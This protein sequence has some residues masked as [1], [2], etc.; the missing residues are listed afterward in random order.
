MMPPRHLHSRFLRLLT[1]LLVAGALPPVAEAREAMLTPPSR[2]QSRA[3]ALYRAYESAGSDAKRLAALERPFRERYRSRP[4]MTGRYLGNLSPSTPGIRQAVS[5]AFLNE[6]ANGTKGARQTLALANALAGDRR[7][8]VTALDQPTQE[9]VGGKW[10]KTDRD[11]VLKSYGIEARIESK[12]LSLATQQKNR[13]KKLKPQ[14]DKMAAEMRRTGKPQYWI[15]ARAI[16]AELAKYAKALGIHVFGNVSSAS[17]P[18]V[19]TPSQVVI[20]DIKSRSRKKA[21]GGGL[22]IGGGLL[23][24]GNGIRGFVSEWNGRRR[25][26]VIAADIVATADGAATTA[27]GLRVLGR[28]TALTRL[29]GPAALLLA[30]ASVGLDIYAYRTGEMRQRELAGSLGSQAAGALGAVVGGI[31]GGLLGSVVPGPGTA[32]G[33]AVGSAVGGGI[34]A[35]WASDQIGDYYSRFDAEHRRRHRATLLEHY[36]ARRLLLRSEF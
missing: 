25:L 13:V 5:Q 16:D 19:R 2:K 10:T 32:I 27:H 9:R 11:I 1:L 30:G 34:A 15:N 14:M 35:W 20:D 29:A 12:D 17:N 4:Q 33:A 24:A 6:S 36:K 22:A 26:R 18:G 23:M 31:G 7:I 3:A 21:L 8:D 28:G